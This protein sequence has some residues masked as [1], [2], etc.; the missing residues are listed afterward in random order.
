M[1]L[2]LII[3]GPLDTVSGGYLYDRKLVDYLRRQGDS[4][5]ILSLPRGS[6]LTHLRD[7]F[8]FRLADHFDLLVQDELNHPSLLVANRQRRAC[9]ILS[10]VHNLRSCEPRPGWQ[11]RFYREVEKYYLRSVDGFIFNSSTTCKTVQA[12]TGDSRPSVIA[13]PGGDRLGFLQ[14]EVVESRA[15]QPGPLRLVFLAN[16]TPLKGLHVALKALRS[17]P[18]E[19]YR[20]EVIGSQDVDPKYM[21]AMRKLM[22]ESGLSGCVHFH[23]ILDGRALAERLAQAQVMVAPSYY[24]GFG[25]A[26]LEGMAFGL[27]VIG[28]TAGA[29]SELITEDKNGYL[30]A[31]G[32]EAALARRL[33]GLAADREQLKRLSLNA[34]HHFHTRPT[35]EQSMQSIREFLFQVIS[36]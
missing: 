14:P 16:L 3:Y 24:E 4:V 9:P 6:Y 13:S 32:D 2:G 26:L 21:Q 18:P 35:W 28:T 36:K 23:G 30:I 34:L 7:N 12:L 25:I 22:D 31:P 8:H 11:N 15:S 27:P 33:A 10:L 1:R 17:L 19:G 29:V 20:L 5:E